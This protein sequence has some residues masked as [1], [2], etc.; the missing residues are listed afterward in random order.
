MANIIYE[1][2]FV[3]DK[4]TEHVCS[5]FDLKDIEEVKTVIP[6]LD[7]EK[8]N[9]VEWN[10]GLILGNSGSGKS[11][12][13]RNIGEIKTPIYNQELSVISQ[14]PQLSEEEAV[15]LLQ[16]VGLSS[17]PLWL[18]KPQELSNGERARLDL[19]WV[20]ANTPQDEII[21]ID[22]FT[23]VVNRHSA[24]AMSFALQRYI[25]QTNRKIILASCHFDIIEWLT[26]DWLYNLN[27]QSDKGC[28]I[29]LIDYSKGYT[30]YNNVDDNEILSEKRSINGEN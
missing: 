17:V 15:N 1:T 22:E 25:R 7:L 14:F 3:K 9:G 27:K 20:I 5:K 24:R 26:S 2:K 4:Y 18:H 28:K 6:M 16:S 23:S 29:E 8:L 12:I 10:I 13:L 11:S 19:A 30:T 21:V